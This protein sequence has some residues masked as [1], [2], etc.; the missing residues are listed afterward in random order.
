[1][2][3][4]IVIGLIIAL[5]IT[6]WYAPKASFQTY[7]ENMNY[8]DVI[9]SHT[10]M[11]KFIETNYKDNIILTQFPEFDEL[12]IIAGGYIKEPLNIVRPKI[13]LKSIK[14]KICFKYP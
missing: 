14:A 9:E 13:N 12:R 8:L 1:M 11:S 10:Q 2:F 4:I 7:E 5:F 3:R 6:Q